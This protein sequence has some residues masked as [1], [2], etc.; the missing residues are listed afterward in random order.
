MEKSSFKKKGLNRV[1]SPEELNDYIKTSRPGSWLIVIAVI[2]LLL[3]VL[4]WGIFGSLESTVTLNGI[5]DGEKLICYASDVSEL[6]TGSEVRLGELIG[7]VTSISEKPLSLEK[8]KAQINT[9]E[10]TLYCLDLKD[11]NYIVEIS[12]P[13]NKT[14]GFVS[15]DVVTEKINPISFIVG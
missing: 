7:E 1:N 3:S 8:T 9:D 12:I 6:E 5:A 14:D 11:W 2:I 15:A 4:V 13:E 10:Y